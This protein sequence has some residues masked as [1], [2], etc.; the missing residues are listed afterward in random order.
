M[1]Y[2][3]R[4]NPV[5][6]VNDLRRFLSAQPQHRVVFLM[7]SLAIVALILFAFVKDSHFEKAYKQDI[8]YV[9]QWKA[10]RTDAEIR[11]KQKVDQVEIDR[12]KAERDAKQKE[13]QAGF[14]RLDDK[15]KAI[16]I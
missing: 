6:A 13:R 14:K 3:T 16:G 10:D 1:R 11:A 4:L 7:L 9:E 8:V 2:P 12:S 15:L 5:A